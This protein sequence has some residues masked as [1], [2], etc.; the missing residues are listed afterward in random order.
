MEQLNGWGQVADFTS[1][2]GRQRGPCTGHRQNL[3]DN[4]SSRVSSCPVQK[5]APNLGKLF[6]ANKN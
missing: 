4:P 3:E 1:Q 2:N 5:A 6:A